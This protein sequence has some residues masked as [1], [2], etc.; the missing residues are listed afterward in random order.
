MLGWSEHIKAYLNQTPGWG[1]EVVRNPKETVLKLVRIEISASESDGRYDVGEPVE[2]VTLRPVLGY[3]VEALGVCSEQSE[4]L[5]R[6]KG[7]P[8]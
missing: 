8:R 1:V 4:T 6:Q 2:I 7:A 3:K 5:P